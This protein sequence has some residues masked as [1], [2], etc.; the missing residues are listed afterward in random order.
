[1][2]QVQHVDML[3]TEGDLNQL[4]DEF[5]D[6]PEVGDVHLRLEDGRAEV[7]VTLS[8]LGFTVPIEAEVRLLDVGPAN[9]RLGLEI[10]NLG[11]L[12]EGIKDVALKKGLES[13]PV[14]GVSY[15][16]GEIRIDLEELLAATPV[17]FEVAGLSLGRDGVRVSLSD[18]R[19]L[20]LS[21]VPEVAALPETT[22]APLAAPSSDSTV[23]VMAPDGDAPTGVALPE[24]QDFYDRLKTRVQVQAQRHLP[25][26]LQPL[27]PWLL[28][29]P[30]SFVLLVR[31]LRDPRVPRRSKWIT[32]LAVAYFIDPLDLIPDAI[33]VLGE[34][35][36]L[37]V[38]LFALDALLVDTPEE[39]LRDLWPGRGD[40]IATVRQGVRFFKQFL[41]RGAVGKIKLLL[42][43]QAPPAPDEADRP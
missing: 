36:D 32:A 12:P 30:D 23:E 35:D 16:Q 21:A 31:L 11:L 28:L 4:A 9:L 7:R 1:M 10:T 6:R 17:R 42:A 18:V 24:H 13:L 5:I 39:V 33:P 15:H 22:E 3:L 41:S 8:K 25:A 43:R 19:Y 34:M 26:R 40:I 37:A 27:V 2:L 38:A 14:R 20:P 29:V